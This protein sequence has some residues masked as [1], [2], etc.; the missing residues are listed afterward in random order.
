[1]AH[2][3]L[4]SR[5]IVQPQGAVE[6]DWSNPLTQGLVFAV[7][8]DNPTN[9]ARR[10]QRN[11]LGAGASS[12]VGVHGRQVDFSG[13]VA[14]FACSWPSSDMY[15]ATESTIE[16]LFYYTNTSGSHVFSQ[17]SSESNHWLLQVSGST[18]AV[19]VPAEDNS[20]YRRRWDGTAFVQ[21][22]WQ[23]VVAS[24]RGGSSYSFVVNGVPKV[25]SAVNSTATSIRSAGTSPVM[26]GTCK[27]GN[28]ITG[29]IAFARAWRRGFTDAEIDSLFQNAYQIFKPVQRR[30]Y[31]D[32]G[33][34]APAGA[35]LEGAASGAA[36]ASGALTTGI[37]IAGAALSV[38]TASG[39]LSVGIQLSGAAASMSSASG[40]LTAQITLS[41]AALAQAV[42]SALLSSGIT[43]TAAAVAQA[44][45][46]GTLVTAIQMLGS[47]QAQAGATGSLT[48]ST[49]GLEGTAQ[50][51]AT[52]SASLTTVIRLSGSAI[53]QAAASG[54]LTAGASIDLAGAAVSAAYASGE[55]TVNI[56]LTAQALAQAI[57]QGSLTAQILMEAD[58]AAQAGAGAAL[59]GGSAFVIPSARTIRAIT[60]GRRPAAIQTTRR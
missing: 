26:L 58:A 19:W 29:S 43:M 59:S 16:L 52:A 20:G 24:W 49:G 42:S 31:F 36:S 39:A 3:I 6:I 25:L 50:A 41:G 56:A 21:N 44:A 27:Y 40:T 48:T 10:V 13:S 55:L 53:A 9:F 51:S 45:A 4:P 46:D 28:D 14:D 22:A 60:G 30:I 17:W 1:M 37:P 8:G 35:V 38:A 12:G 23:H 5:R 7:E 2:L 32:V 34:S 18:G 33:A 15:G 54:G 47:A 57:A 11:V